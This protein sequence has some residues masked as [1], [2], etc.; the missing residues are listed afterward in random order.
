MGRE[1]NGYSLHSEFDLEK[2]K[3]RFVHCL[4]IMILPDGSVQYAIPSHTKKAERLAAESLG[5]SIEELRSKC[6]REYYCDYMEWLLQI[7]GAVAVWT[8]GCKYHQVTSKQIAMLR[9]MKMAGVYEGMIP[10]ERIKRNKNDKF[11]EK[12]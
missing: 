7:S 5:I 12:S 1:I 10:N 4:E 2:H 8:G 11:T 6:P 3:Q 9:K